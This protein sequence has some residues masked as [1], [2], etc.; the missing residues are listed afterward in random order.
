MKKA[1]GKSGIMT[2][3]FKNKKLQL[4]IEDKLQKYIKDAKEQG[5]DLNMVSNENL[6][7]TIRLNENVDPLSRAISAD[8]P[9][10]RRIT[11]A[12]LGK[13]KAPVVDINTGKTM[14]TSQGIMGGKSVAELMKSGQVTK[15]ARGMKKS[16]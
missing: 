15:G 10:G 16:K 1:A 13:Q 14:D 11:E 8:S 4:D 2:V 7:A 3:P 5:V 6:K 12:L 9:E